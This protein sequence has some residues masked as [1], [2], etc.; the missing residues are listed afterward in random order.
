MIPLDQHCPR[1]QVG[2][3]TLS[4]PQTLKLTTSAGSPFP[5]AESSRR[6]LPN[7]MRPNL[8]SG[9][10][11]RLMPSS[12]MSVHK[13]ANELESMCYA[14]SSASARTDVRQTTL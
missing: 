4:G 2:L 6:A 12:N 10:L 3:Q 1:L 13:W 11:Q 7:A 14:T 8:Q 9:P 5:Y